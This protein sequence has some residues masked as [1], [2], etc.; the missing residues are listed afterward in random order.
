[1]IAATLP[2]FKDA[3]KMSQILIKEFGMKKSKNRSKNLRN[4]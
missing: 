4:D 2:N 1:M 3:I